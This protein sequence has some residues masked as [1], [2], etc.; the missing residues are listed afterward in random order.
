MTESKR[1]KKLTA[2]PVYRR[3]EQDIRTKILQGLWPDNMLIPSRTKLVEEYGVG[4]PTIEHA[5][6]LL[7]EAGLLRAESR[8][9]T[10]VEKD[11][12]ARL[13]LQLE[14]QIE[15]LP[16]N[17]DFAN[18]VN[19]L[20]EMIALKGLSNRR[21]APILGITSADI[22][23]MPYHKE[24]GM[25][26]SARVV[27]ALE[28]SFSQAGGRVHF[29]QRFNGNDQLF[30]LE[31]AI[32]S[33]LFHGAEALAIV[34][35]VHIQEVSDQLSALLDI[36]QIPVMLH[37]W[38]SGSS[39]LPW[40]TYDSIQAGYQAAKHL[41]EMGYEPLIFLDCWNEWWASE[42]LKGA[43]AAVRNAGLAEEMLLVRRGQDAHVK[44]HP[45]S[46][47]EGVL[48]GLNE[49]QVFFENQASD[50]VYKYKR[51]GIIA[52]TDSIAH[53]VLQAALNAGK[54]AG[55]DFGL[56][57]F[58]DINS[59]RDLGLTSLVPPLEEMGSE[60]ARQIIQQLH[61][62]AIPSYTALHSHLIARTSTDAHP[63]ASRLYVLSAAVKKG[64]TGL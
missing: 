38:H 21:T 40:I 37:S 19:P 15:V 1:I 35:A 30:S 28:R 18:P 53:G 50:S 52:P 34:N 58:D 39:S 5:I 24:S 49:G 33:L 36:S 27:R 56:V 41:L 20:P 22:P 62:E 63:K 64:E 47:T 59:S 4:M 17:G 7:I 9:G 43:H 2:I 8:K 29:L 46:P 6:D 60:M 55:I 11:A 45:P 13:R 51:P 23:L 12:Q 10:F 25:D 57:G 42:R 48:V 61:G 16:Q 44:D 32:L 31:E 3:I 54:V 26:W 14:A